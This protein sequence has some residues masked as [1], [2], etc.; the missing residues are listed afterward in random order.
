MCSRPNL[1]L[2]KFF[3]CHSRQASAQASHEKD[4]VRNSPFVH[5]STRANILAHILSNAHVLVSKA[6]TGMH[7]AACRCCKTSQHGV[8]ALREVL[9][10][11]GTSLARDGR[12]RSSWTSCVQDVC[13]HEQ[14][15]TMSAQR[16]LDNRRS[17][18]K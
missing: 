1:S 11:H 12:C 8:H 4:A 15:C 17:Q 6:D 9:S 10:K 5:S 18:Q 14:S 13:V 3:N 2:V 16:E 7:T